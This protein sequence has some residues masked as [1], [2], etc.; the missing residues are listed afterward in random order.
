M[1]ARIAVEQPAL[2]AG[3]RRDG[4]HVGVVELDILDLEVL[5]AAPRVGRFRDRQHTELH[6]PAQDDLRR[7]AAM[8][9]GDIGDDGLGEE[10]QKPSFWI[11]RPLLEPGSLA[12]ILMGLGAARP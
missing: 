8:L 12:R 1:R 5:L 2:L 3:E 4:G 6:M 10:C 7:G 9:V 11:I